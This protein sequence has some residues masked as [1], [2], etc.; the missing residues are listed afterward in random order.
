M[1]EPIIIVKQDSPLTIQVYD[2]S[3]RR[4]IEE[5]TCN[6]PGIRLQRGKK[7]V[8]TEKAGKGAEYEIDFG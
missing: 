2:R 8:C 6:D 3:G 5:F 4:F 7:P 1:G